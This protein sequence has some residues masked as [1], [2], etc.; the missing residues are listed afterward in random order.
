MRECL[1]AF[2]L[3][4]LARTIPIVAS[5]LVEIWISRC[6]KYAHCLHTWLAFV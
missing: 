4:F 5:D 1:F 2:L 6:D 3:F